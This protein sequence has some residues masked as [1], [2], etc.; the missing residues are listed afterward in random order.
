ML[1]S[2]GSPSK[3]APNLTSP[4]ENSQL[5]SAGP[6][7]LPEIEV[8]DLSSLGIALPDVHEQTLS[9]LSGSHSKGAKSVSTPALPTA[10]TFSTAFTPTTFRP[11]S[12]LPAL[13][14]FAPSVDWE[15]NVQRVNKFF[16]ELGA[17]IKQN[18]EVIQKVFPTPM[19]VL[20]KIVQAFFRLPVR[21]F[22]DN[23]LS[24]STRLDAYLKTLA[25]AMLKV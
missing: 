10:S 8:L 23:L 17:E 14:Q 18:N 13:S 11:K 21:A 20:E 4:R 2:S 5:S 19:I 7:D 12:N 15:E 24:D 3:T 9:A 6:D 22:L 25:H 16:T 1:K